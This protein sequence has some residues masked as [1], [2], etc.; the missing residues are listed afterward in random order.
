MS[1][2]PRA[3]DVIC[4]S[5]KIK[6]KTQEK[7]ALQANEALQRLGMWPNTLSYADL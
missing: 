4:N 6:K 7:S 3:A 5:Q 1:D 2:Q